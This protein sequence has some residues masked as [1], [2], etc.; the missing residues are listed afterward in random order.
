M[1]KQEIFNKI[2][3]Q[4]KEFGL[5]VHTE[6]AKDGFN[7][8]CFVRDESMNSLIKQIKTEV[9]D[10]KCKDHYEYLASRNIY[11]PAYKSYLTVNYDERTD[12]INLNEMYVG[13]AYGRYKKRIYPVR[14]RRNILTFTDSMYMFTSDKRNAPRRFKA[15]VIPYQN[16]YT[17]TAIK[18]MLDIDFDPQL[19]ISLKNYFV[20]QDEWDALTTHLGYRVPRTIRNFNK[21]AAYKIMSVINRDDLLKLCIEIED[22]YPEP[23]DIRFEKQGNMGSYLYKALGNVVLGSKTFD[24]YMTELVDYHYQLKTKVSLDKRS[25]ETILKE[26][27]TA[28]NKLDAKIRK[29]QMLFI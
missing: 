18:A 20:A 23:M 17:T 10:A 8:V 1:T 2:V 12:K 22:N 21:Y 28:Q 4:Y 3:E 13:Y 15:N 24:A 16:L 5:R 14:T 7:S 25:E 19:P 27:V 11:L 6:H 9:F 29:Q 26:I